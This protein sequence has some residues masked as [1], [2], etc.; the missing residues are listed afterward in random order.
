MQLTEKLVPFVSGAPRVRLVNAFARPYENALATARTCYSGKGIVSVA[1]VSG[2]A[3][4]DAGKR[5]AMAERRDDLARS[6]YQAGHHTTLQHAHFQF[7]LENVSRHFIWSFLHAHPYYNSEQVSQRYVEVKAGAVAVPALGGAALATYQAAVERQMAEYRL[8]IEKLTPPAAAAYFKLFPARRSNPKYL[9]D[10]KKKAQEVARYVL[11]VATTAHMYHTVSGLTL[12]RYWRVAQSIEVGPETLW[13]VGRMVEEMLKVDPLFQNILEEPLA[14]EET[15]EWA[16]AQAAVPQLKPSRFRAEFDAELAGRVSALVDWKVNNEPVL[17]QSVRE[18]LGL[19][20]D[21]M[22][23]ADALRLVLDPSRNGLLGETMN[24]STLSKL[25]RCLFHPAYTFRKKLSHTADSQDQRH[26]MTP[27][28]RPLT[29]LHLDGEPDYVTPGLIE[30]DPECQALYRASMERSWQAFRD[31]RALGVS[32]DDAAYVLPNA[33]AVRFTES[34][35]LLNLH[36]KL[37][38]RLCYNSQ[39]EIWRASRDEALQ[40]AN[41]N[42]TIGRYLLPPCG[43]RAMARVSPICPEG[44]RYCGVP[45]W[46]LP[47]EKYQRVI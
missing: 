18:V 36:H 44:E 37:K 17:A 30:T 13:V 3:E 1:D 2:D 10:V 26:R 20:R 42:P 22:A 19:G 33:L 8:L 6:I 40:I 11:P 5:A 45:V 7:A 27:A 28:S 43:L 47:V 24:V 31:L 14:L 32:A 34:A 29:A 23:D 15:P 41:V 35:D 39:E 16:A 38:A 12:L 46:R 4:P 25:S 21:Q 9:R